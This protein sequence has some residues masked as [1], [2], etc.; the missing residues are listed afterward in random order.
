MVLVNPDF[1]KD[2]IDSV[3]TQ[4]GRTITVYTPQATACLACVAAGDYD[5]KSDTS[6]NIVCPQCN[7]A[8]W[9]N[10][11]DGTDVLARIHW[12]GNEA[13]TATPGGK[14]YLGDAQVTVDPMYRALFEAAQNEAGRVDVDGQHFQILKIS[15][16]GAPTINRIR[17]VLR[18]MGARPETAQ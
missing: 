4:I 11:V 7:G 2:Q 14:Y 13:I 1:I 9:I 12:V 5:P 15:P 16:M 6:F 3:R 18:G 10:H 17:I 8:Y